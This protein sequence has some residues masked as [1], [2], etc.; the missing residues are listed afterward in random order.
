MR[1]LRGVKSSLHADV[2]L[3][4]ATLEPAAASRTQ[5]ER[6]LDL[7]HAQ[8]RAIEL[9]RCTLTPLRGGDLNMIDTDDTLFHRSR[10]SWPRNFKRP[11]DSYS[12]FQSNSISIAALR[13]FSLRVSM[14]SRTLWDASRD[15]WLVS[16]SRF[17]EEH[18]S[19]RRATRRL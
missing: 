16:L 3:L 19:L 15:S 10:V 12:R 5:C 4:L 1:L 7:F 11:D 14:N 9:S 13:Q 2:H 6:F 18:R 8:D 17:L